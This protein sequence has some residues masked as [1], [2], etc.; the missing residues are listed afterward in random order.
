MKMDTE[1]LMTA[2]KRSISEVLETMFFLPLDFSRAGRN[3]FL[4]TLAA[5]DIL[6]A[7]L[8]F[9]GPFDGFCMLYIPASLARSISL[10][11]MGKSDGSVTTEQVEATVKELV[12][13]ITGNTFAGYDQGA[14]FDLG[15]PE[16]V[17]GG[18]SAENRSE[19]ANAMLIGI[20][21]LE[22]KLAFEIVATS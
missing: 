10:D 21:T 19:A 14:V 9:E 1:A 13:M 8:E 22:N 17:D 18:L 5:D 20:N 11:F 16:L 2:V 6:A 4:K 3:E 12:N 15:I 7:R